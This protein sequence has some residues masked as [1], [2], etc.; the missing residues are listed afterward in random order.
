MSDRSRLAWRGVSA[1]DG[2][3]DPAVRDLYA[4][5]AARVG[6]DQFVLTPVMVGVFFSSMALGEG[7][8]VDEVQRR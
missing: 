1:L 3:A 5:V 4:V 8:G 7:K 2:T 6:L